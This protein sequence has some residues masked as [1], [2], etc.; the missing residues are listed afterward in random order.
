MK[1]ITKGLILAGVFALC[2]S[3]GAVAAK[4]LTGTDIINGSLTGK[5]FKKGSIGEGRLSDDVQAK[6]NTT[7]SGSSAAQGPKG[8]TGPAGP[9]GPKGDKGDN[10]AP[11]LSDLEADG[12]Y[13][14]AAIPPL[15]GA[16]GDQSTAKWHAYCA[17]R[18]TRTYSARRVQSRSRQGRARRRLR[19]QR[20]SKR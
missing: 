7:V 19:P 17:D 13:P 18:A 5:E 4:K 12:P 2:M 20:R 11:G 16:Q 1:R 15:S 14:G 6:L 3:G 9:R 8:D 10:G